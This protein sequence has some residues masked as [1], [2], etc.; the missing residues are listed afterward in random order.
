MSCP[1]LSIIIPVYNARPYVR[2]C[3]E[4]LCRQTYPRLE[5]LFVDDCST[6]GS[7]EECTR[8]CAG[9]PRFRVLRMPENS[10]AGDTRQRGIEAATGSWIGFTDCDD[11]PEPELYA[12]LYRTAMQAQADIACCNAFYAYEDGRHWPI[13]PPGTQVT[14]L[15][16]R[17]ALLRMHRREGIGY[18]LWD[19]LFR[20]EILL[21]VPMRSQPFEDH[22]TLPYYFHAARRIALCPQP[23]YRY[24]QHEGSLMHGGF[25]A[26]KELAGFRLFY[27]ETQLLEK[28]YGITGLNTVVKKGVHYLNHLC[29]LPENEQVRA[30]RDE[31]ATCIRE[32]DGVPIRPYS[33]SLRLKRYMLLNHYATWRSMYLLFMKGFKRSKYKKMNP[34][35]LI[36]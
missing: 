17:E 29:L 13:F 16:P 10:G 15:T 3:F 2:R 36:H 33:L 18:S 5:F 32:Y 14:E 35:N 1:L 12:T 8:I 28:A 31:V 19:K 9:D 34:G 20:R 26:R 6:D 22:A 7:Y 21:Q 25:D 24:I 27:K 11:L 30:W 23:L 4:A